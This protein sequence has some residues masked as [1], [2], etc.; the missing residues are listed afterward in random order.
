MSKFSNTLKMLLTPGTPLCALTYAVIGAV[1]A[2]L[3]LSVGLWK[4]LFVLAFA[5]VGAFLGGVTN[6]K[7][8]VAGAVNRVIPPKNQPIKVDHAELDDI[9][10]DSKNETEDKE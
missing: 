1:I 9:L 4:T 3:L 8:A 6:K 10:G 2:I 7:E 5:L